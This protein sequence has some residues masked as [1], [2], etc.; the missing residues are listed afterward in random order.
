M[1]QT[2]I[3]MTSVNLCEVLDNSG[4]VPAEAQNYQIALYFIR[5]FANIYV[6]DAVISNRVVQMKN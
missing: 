6:G 2:K 1:A 5:Q 3:R 4:A